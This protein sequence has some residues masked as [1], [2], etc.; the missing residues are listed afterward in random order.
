MRY[1]RR[2]LPTNQ[3][4][5]VC[6]QSLAQ[7]GRLQWAV[8]FLITMLSPIHAQA[9]TTQQQ[10][11]EAKPATAKQTDGTRRIRAIRAQEEIHIDGVLSEPSWNLAPAATDFLQK[12]PN[13][14]APA[15]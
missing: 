15:S 14:G 9:Q 1:V 10:P 6:D 13:E 4:R 2:I 5:N 3:L 8:L 11:G 7:I 12:E